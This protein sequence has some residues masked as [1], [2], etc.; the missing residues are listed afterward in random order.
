MKCKYRQG[1]KECNLPAL[2]NS[3]DPI[4]F[5]KKFERS[6]KELTKKIVKAKEI[7]SKVR[8]DDD[9]LRFLTKTVVEMGIKTNRAE[10]S[11]IKTAKTIAALDGRKNVSLEDIKKGVWGSY[12]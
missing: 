12:A 5:Y 11:T 4:G 1:S 3:K 6:E 8:V 2:K 10:I 9:L 7:L